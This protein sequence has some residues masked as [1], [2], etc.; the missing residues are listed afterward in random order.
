M[1]IFFKCKFIFV[2][3]IIFK[4]IEYLIF[5]PKNKF[6]SIWSYILKIM[7]FLIFR[8]FSRNFPIILNLLGFL[9]FKILILSHIVVIADTTGE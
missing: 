6:R 9:N 3:F 2:L 4:M 1:S 7:N 8:D 5:N